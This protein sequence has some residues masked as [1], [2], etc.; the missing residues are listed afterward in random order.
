MANN[1]IIRENIFKG[2]IGGLTARGTAK[3]MMNRKAGKI[4]SAVERPSQS[5]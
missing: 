5:V 1:P 4:R 3:P 2:L